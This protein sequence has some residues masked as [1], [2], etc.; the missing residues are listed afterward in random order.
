MNETV[1]SLLVLASPFRSLSPP[2]A[3]RL[4]E[5]KVRVR[6]KRRQEFFD[7]TIYR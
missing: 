6:L 4:T 3:G 2:E 1:D 7:A 5:E